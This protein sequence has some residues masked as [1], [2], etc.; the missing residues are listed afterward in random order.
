[1]KISVG[2]DGRL[3]IVDKLIH[4]LEKRGH[5]VIWH[6]PASLEDGFEPYP[7]I[8]SVVTND[9]VEGRAEEAVICCFTGTG[10][11][12]AANKTK[13]IRAAL[14]HDA[15]TAKGARLWNAANV[16]TLSLRLTSDVVLDE[17]LD[18]WFENK[19]EP[20]IDAGVDLGVSQLLELDK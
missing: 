17:I 6:G 20:G 14:C 15:F 8:A 13:G 4:S 2:A 18:A 10:I 16:L 12:I 1:M 5:D 11:T 9:V 7:T 3:P 19:Y